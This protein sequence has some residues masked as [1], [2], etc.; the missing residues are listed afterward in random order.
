MIFHIYCGR[1]KIRSIIW[2]RPSIHGSQYDRS[3]A[4]KLARL[5]LRGLILSKG[6]SLLVGQTGELA[7]IKHRDAG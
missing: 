4:K 5:S 7:T 6:R 1:L 2:T 3:I